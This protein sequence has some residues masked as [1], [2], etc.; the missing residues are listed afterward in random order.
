MKVATAIAILAVSMTAMLG[1]AAPA[2]AVNVKTDLDAY[3][4]N[5]PGNL[6]LVRP[7]NGDAEFKIKRN[8]GTV[9]YTVNFSGIQ[10]GV[11]MAHIHLGNAWQN[12][13]VMVWLCETAAPFVAPVGS[14]PQCPGGTDGTI[15]GT[16]TAADVVGSG[17]EQI[18]SGDFDTLLDL[19]DAGAAYVLV[20]SS[21]FIPGEIRGQFDGK[22]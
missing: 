1:I 11:I 10:S 14:P 21:E 15:T 20:H 9:D 12:G 17:G 6:P 22:D 8:K 7:S 16:F 2:G 19:I 18:S 4:I 3:S 5:R 13:P